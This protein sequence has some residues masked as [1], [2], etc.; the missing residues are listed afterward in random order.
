MFSKINVD[1]C[2]TPDC[3]NMGVLNSPDYLSQGKDVLCRECGFLFPVISERSLNL[4]RQSVNRAWQGLIKACP[5]CGSS[6]L[7]KY[8]FS[9]QGEPR[10][11]CLMCHKTFIAPGEHKADARQDSLAQLIQGGS[12]LADIRATLSLDSTGLNRALQKLSRKVNQAERAFIFPAFD[13]A[14][15]TRAFRV[16][17]NGSDNCLYVLVTAEE[18]SGRVIAITTNY[19]SQPVENNYQYISDYEERLPPGTLAHLVQRKELMTM[20]RNTLFDVDYGPATLYKNDPGML[21]KPVLPAYRHFELVKVLT[22]DRSL[23]VQHYIDHECFIL[24]GCL[25]ANL[26]HVRQG[27]CHISFVREHGD[28]PPGRD[29]P[30]RIF[31]SGGIRNNVWRTFSTRDYSKAVCNLT[32]DKKTSILRHATLTGATRFI[33][34]L[35]AHPFF[36]QLCRLSPANVTVTLNYL[37]YEYNKKVV[38]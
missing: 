16:K 27:R 10:M 14:M 7:K 36:F 11:Y 32:G 30:Y 4:F 21:V 31:R 23:N 22:D 28:L 1:A 8:G 19:S 6:S 26:T 33:H 12:S 5:G 17:Y 37:K 18:S 29:I 2:K 3:K 15:S 25:M 13:L 34:F 9:A 35:H 38:I 24:G 20:R